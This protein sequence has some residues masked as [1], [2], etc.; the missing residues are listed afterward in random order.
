MAVVRPGGNRPEWRRKR[1]RKDAGSPQSAA[2]FFVL[3]LYGGYFSVIKNGGAPIGWV[4]LVIAGSSSKNRPRIAVLIPAAGSGKR[5][6][7]KEN[8]V[9]LPICGAAMIARAA[10]V[11]QSHAAVG[12]IRVIAQRADFAPLER[13]FA[14]RTHWSKVAPLVEGGRERQESVRN[15]ILVL[16]GAE[17][18]ARPPE[19]VLVHDG[20]RPFCPPELLERVLSALR[21]WPAVVP[22]LPISDT[23]RRLGPD[24]GEVVERSGL[25]RC[26]TPQG[27]HLPLLRRAHQRAWENGTQATDDAQLVEALGERIHFVPGDEQNFKITSENDLRVAERFLNGPRRRTE[28]GG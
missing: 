26:Q 10:E 9:L 18:R 19:W 7:A 28:Q 5:A 14:D 8:K 17:A 21:E 24:G 15:G 16:D 13:I 12:E 4:V 27:F 11:F 2:A 20:A 25:V 1:P 3:W 6:G 23:V 22:T